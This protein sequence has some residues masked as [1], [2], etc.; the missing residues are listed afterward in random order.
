MSTPN[1]VPAAVRRLTAILEQPVSKFSKLPVPLLD[2]TM[3][4]HGFSAPEKAAV[5]VFHKESAEKEPDSGVMMIKHLEQRTAETHHPYLIHMRRIATQRDSHSQLSLDEMRKRFADAAKNAMLSKEDVLTLVYLLYGTPDDRALFA[6]TLL[7]YKDHA[8]IQAHNFFVAEH[9]DPAFLVTYGDKLIDFEYPLFPWTEEFSSLNYQLLNADT[10]SGKG[11]GDHPCEKLYL[12]KKERSQGKV[13]GG[14]ASM[15]VVPVVS[16]Q[17]GRSYVDLTAMVGACE[18]LWQKTD[19]LEK[20]VAEMEV[21]D[22]KLNTIL[23]RG[24]RGLRD[25]VLYIG[26][27]MQFRSGR[28]LPPAPPKF[29]RGKRLKKPKAAGEGGSDDD[30]SDF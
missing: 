22:P 6:A 14:Q 15:G 24:L 28:Q 30:G 23:Y 16:Q 21:K 11:D 12:R 26:R 9:S 3:R 2:D 17:D 25:S 1:E 29:P 8:R 27:L 10:V 19:N 5:H 7:H 13:A 18:S 20:K 4:E